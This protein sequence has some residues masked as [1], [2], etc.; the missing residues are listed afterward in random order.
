MFTL[1]TKK[2]T[3]SVTVKVLSQIVVKMDKKVKS[4]RVLKILTR[5]ITLSTNSLETILLLSKVA[6][7]LFGEM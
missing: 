4:E 5:N 1:W 3:A 6:Q 7:T 2:K